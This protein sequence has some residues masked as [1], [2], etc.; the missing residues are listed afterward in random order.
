MENTEKVR[1][2]GNKPIRIAT[3]NIQHCL[4]YTRRPATGAE[5]IDV[6]K[7][8]DVIRSMRLDFCGLNEV[9]DGVFSKALRQPQRLAKGA[10]LRWSLFARAIRLPDMW[11]GNALLSA[12]PVVR[13]SAK[14]IALLPEERAEEGYYEQRVLLCADLLVGERELTV[15]VCHIGLTPPEQEKAVRLIC[16]AIDNATHPVVLMGDFN[17]TPDSPYYGVLASRLTDTAS[18]LPPDELLSF[19]SDR[20]GVKIDYIFVGK[21]V[22]AVSAHI[23][24]V[25]CSDHRPYV[26]EITFD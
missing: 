6:L 13:H 12:C 5:A 15:L 21:G 4:D 3:F 14:K 8:A 11:Y 22:H 20:P 19:P 1:R 23:P 10:G 25:V 7:F 2:D 16:Q 9:Y 18:L 26:A 24:P 17:F